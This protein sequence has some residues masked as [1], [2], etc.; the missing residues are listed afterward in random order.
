MNTFVLGVLIPVYNEENM[1]ERMFDRLKR[2]PP[3][4]LPDGSG[5]E[6]RIYFIN[7]GSTDRSKEIIDSL[8]DG[9][10][11]IAIHQP[12]NQGKGSAI[13]A[14]FKRSIKDG[15]DVLIIQDADMEY[16]PADHDAVLA[17]I[18][19]G[20]ADAVIGTRFLGQT[21]RVLYY[22]H[23]IANRVIT[24]FS[25]MLSNLN[26][27]DIECGYK[28]FTKESIKDIRITEE[29]FGLEP[30]LVAKL[31]KARIEDADTKLYRRLRIYEV[32]ISYAGRTYEEGK[33]IG[34]K[35]GVEALWCIVKHNVFG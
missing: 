12:S 22:W 20:R 32:P 5:V 19:D 15:C 35:D 11:V 28:A 7:D 31:A 34:W 17:P 2:T 4:T 29:R 24:L 18:L 9:L 6:R 21:H 3:P 23:S 10:E 8:S 30:E 13:N 33:K 25:N 14:G 1:L 16:D 27:T 26:L